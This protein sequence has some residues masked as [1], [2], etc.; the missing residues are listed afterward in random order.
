MRYIK[1]IK[2]KGRAVYLRTTAIGNVLNGHVI[3]V[4][5]SAENNES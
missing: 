2:V 4:Y 1:K 3:T 5:I